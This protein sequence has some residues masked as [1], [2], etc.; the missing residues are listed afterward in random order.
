VTAYLT[1]DGNVMISGA[2]NDG[3][4]CD[5]TDAPPTTVAIDVERKD[6]RLP[7]ASDVEA[8]FDSPPLDSENA[9]T[10]VLHRRK[11]TGASRDFTMVL[12]IIAAMV[13]EGIS[14]CGR[15]VC[16][17]CFSGFWCQFCDLCVSCDVLYRINWHSC[18]DGTN[19]GIERSNRSFVPD[20]YHY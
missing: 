11:M 4:A 7:D 6:L 18:T 19:R 2:A 15:I 9:A 1:P 20:R 8:A 17:G 5:K 10:S 12:M 16:C 14:E 3:W 13:V